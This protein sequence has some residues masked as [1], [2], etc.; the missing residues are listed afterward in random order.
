M[1]GT[2]IL[3]DSC[4]VKISCH[5]SNCQ[6]L[7]KSNLSSLLLGVER[8]DGPQFESKHSSLTFLQRFSLLQLFV[9][10]NLNFGNTTKSLKSSSFAVFSLPR[11]SFQAS[12]TLQKVP[13]CT[14]LKACE[15]SPHN[16]KYSLRYKDFLKFQLLIIAKILVYLVLAAV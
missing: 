14:A 13:G 6:Q 5:F 10:G 1:A 4:D 12:S 8:A 9:P 3:L 2:E 7:R 16:S 15:I 11:V